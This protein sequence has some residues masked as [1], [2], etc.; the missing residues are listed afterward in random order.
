VHDEAGWL[1]LCGTGFGEAEE[2]DILAQAG[3]VFLALAL[4]LDAEEVY[5]IHFGENIVEAVADADAEFFKTLG[6]RD[7]SSNQ[8]RNTNWH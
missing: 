6:D 7:R 2:G 8:V 1:E 4:V 3:E 5:D